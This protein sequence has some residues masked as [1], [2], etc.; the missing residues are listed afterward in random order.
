[1]LFLVS[2]IL[3]PGEG[4]NTFICS[5][6][7]KCLFVKIT[8]YSHAGINFSTVVNAKIGTYSLFRKTT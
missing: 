3:Y 4:S 5:F 1:M 2:F 7:F 8:L 6:A